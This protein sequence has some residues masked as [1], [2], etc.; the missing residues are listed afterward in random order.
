MTLPLT[1]VNVFA[2]GPSTTP[3]MPDKALIRALFKGYEDFISAFT[4]NGGLVYPNRST[5][6]ADLAH[7]ANS[8]AWVAT[9]A[10][11]SYNGIYRKVGASGSGSWSRILDLPFSFIIASDDGAGG[12]DTLQVTTPVPVSSS[13]LIVLNVYEPNTGS[14]VTVSFNGGVPLTIKTAS[15]FDI[16]PGALVPGIGYIVGSTFRMMSDIAS[17]AI[18][19]AAAAS[20][21]QASDI[22]GG[23]GTLTAAVSLATASATNAASSASASFAN[24]KADTSI[25]SA[26]AR[27]ADGETFLVINAALNQVDAYRRESSTTQ[28]YLTTYTTALSGLPPES[29]WLFGIQDQ[30]NGLA[31]GVDKAGKVW[32]NPANDIPGMLPNGVITKDDVTDEAGFLFVVGDANKNAGFGLKKDGTFWC[33]TSADFQLSN[34]TLTLI[35]NNTF[36]T[37]LPYATIEAWGDSLT[38]GAGGGA[39]TYPSVLATALGRTVNNRGIGGQNSSAIATRQGGLK[40]LVSV[41]SNQI[42]ASGAVTLTARSQ[43]PIT[44]QGPSSFTGTLSGVTGTLAASTS[45]GGATYTYTFTRTTAGAIVPCPANS[46]FIFDIAEAAKGATA[47]I[48][49]GRN[50]GLSTRSAVV[51]TR[52]DILSMAVKLTPLDK[53]FLV[54]SVLNGAG[55]TTGTGAFNQFAAFNAELQATFGDRFVDVR[56]YLVNFGLADAGITPTTQDNTDVAG[57]TVPASLRSDGIHLNAAGYT[58]VG[59]FI[60]R[61]IRARGW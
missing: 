49:S 61:Q 36:K 38:A 60:A 10:T 29:G 52:D 9:D 22:V 47:I 8:Q 37:L 12:P 58:L 45:D 2:D 4:T 44:N 15:G 57:N 5:L 39:T 59:N 31:F 54:M 23:L 40:M 56:S 35:N 1:A 48:W 55:E 19:N 20:A 14:P 17:S 3:T 18:V 24:A 7:D 41:T 13:A 42:P 25:S 33:K 28:T 53:R 50:N 11:A 6:Y 34:D 16:P 30:A 26:R 46:E 21:A 32:L 51:A 27:V 43:T